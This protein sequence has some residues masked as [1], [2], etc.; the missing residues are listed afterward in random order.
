MTNIWTNTRWQQ[1]ISTAVEL[2][3]GMKSKEK[4]EQFLGII[5]GLNSSGQKNL[6]SSSLTPIQT[7]TSIFICA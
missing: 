3:V 1:R 6:N 7:A 5:K 2:A 4:K